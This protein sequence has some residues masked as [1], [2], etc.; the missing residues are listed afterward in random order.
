MYIFLFPSVIL[1]PLFMGCEEKRYSKIYDRTQTGI[2]LREVRVATASPQLKKRLAEALKAEGI[3]LSEKAPLTL[4]VE[5][6]RY[7]RRCNNPTTCAYD[8][9][10]D[11]FAK[12]TLMRDMHPIYMVQ[13]D[14]HGALDTDIFRDLIGQMRREMA[15]D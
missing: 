13:R 11:G 6:T 15:A 1:L 10:Y 5:A 12:L 7:S 14:Y 3:V 9:T 2:P 4:Q 8:A